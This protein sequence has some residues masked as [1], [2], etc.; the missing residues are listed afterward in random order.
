ML[1]IFRALLYVVWLASALAAW[2][3]LE[4]GRNVAGGVLI[5]VVVVV[6][7]LE[8]AIARYSGRP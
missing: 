7:L 1:W 4:N 6:S 3:A 5:G 2:Q 8:L